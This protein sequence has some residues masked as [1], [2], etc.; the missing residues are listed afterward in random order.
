MS[1]SQ[2]HNFVENSKEEQ[3]KANFLIHDAFLAY[4]KN[5]KDQFRLAGRVSSFIQE[6]KTT[7]HSFWYLELRYRRSQILVQES[8]GLNM[9]F[10]NRQAYNI[11]EKRRV[12][13][14][15]DGYSRTQLN[16]NYVYNSRLTFDFSLINFLNYR[17]T[18][19]RQ[20]SDIPFRANYFNRVVFSPNFKI[21]D[22]LES[23]LGIFYDSG[24]TTRDFSLRNRGSGSDD[25]VWL[26]PSFSFIVNN[27]LTIIADHGWGIYRSQDGRN[28]LGTDGAYSRANNIHEWGYWYGLTFSFNVF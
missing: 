25:F 23:S 17:N 20:N 4:A 19:N 1:Y 13:T 27:Y 18:S 11:D 2:S 24:H 6:R 3:F 14:G 28:G 10:E 12:S 22:K 5:K 16:F 8:H 7:E 21:S 9:S 15:S 26:N